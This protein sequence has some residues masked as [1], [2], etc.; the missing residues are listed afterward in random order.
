MS[1]TNWVTTPRQIYI[2]MIIYIGMNP[3]HQLPVWGIYKQRS[4]EL[5]KKMYIYKYREREKSKVKLTLIF[6]CGILYIQHMLACYVFAYL[7][8]TWE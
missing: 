2:Y 5:K 1:M 7:F 4:T 8:N 3:L 6:L